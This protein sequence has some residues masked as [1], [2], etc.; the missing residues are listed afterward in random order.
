[1]LDSKSKKL[2]EELE[3][4]FRAD[5]DRH[6]QSGLNPSAV[7]FVLLHTLITWT[8]EYDHEDG[9]RLKSISLIQS[10][11]ARTIEKIL[12]RQFSKHA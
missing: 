2:F 1:M 3:V 6:I 4:S 11:T 10:V 8:L 9:S 12:D 5:L 7:L